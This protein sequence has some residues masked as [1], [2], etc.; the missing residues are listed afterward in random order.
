MSICTTVLSAVVTTSRVGGMP[1]VNVV[2]EELAKVVALA[3]VT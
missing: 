2:E 3:K 1:I